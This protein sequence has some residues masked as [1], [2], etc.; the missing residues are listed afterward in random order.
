MHLSAVSLPGNVQR[1]R[2]HED[3]LAMGNMFKEGDLVSAEVQAVHQDGSVSL[4]TRSSKYGKLENGLL[5]TVKQSLVKRC[6]QHFVELQ[7][8]GI[9]MILGNNG[10]IWLSRKL[11][12]EEIKEKEAFDSDESGTVTRPL[13][14]TDLE[15]RVLISRIRNAIIA[16]SLQ[17]IPIHPDTILMVFEDSA[18]IEVKEMLEKEE[19]LFRITARAHQRSFLL[20]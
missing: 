2:T 18:D 16:L 20:K 10:N 5:V 11:T 13:L 1:K 14:A 4:H 7:Q 8:T 3:A 12:P 15:Q 6:K 19:T 9:M 17:S